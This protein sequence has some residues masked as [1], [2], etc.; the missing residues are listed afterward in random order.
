MTLEHGDV[1]SQ[2]KSHD[3][4]HYQLKTIQLFSPMSRSPIKC[5]GGSGDQKRCKSFSLNIISRGENYIAVK[6]AIQSSFRQ[7]Y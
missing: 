1:I 2:L 3:G 5:C 4:V 6:V 7:S